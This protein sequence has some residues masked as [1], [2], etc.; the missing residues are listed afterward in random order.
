MSEFIEEQVLTAA[1]ADD[2][3]GVR[4]LLAKMTEG[5][6]D[7]ML[8]AFERIEG[9]AA[10]YCCACGEPVGLLDAERRPYRWE[11]DYR[12]KHTGCVDPVQHEP[13]QSES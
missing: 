13:V 10:L 12:R 5:E 9:I 7:G 3:E 8:R 1:L 4:Q 2:T 11:G 6:Q